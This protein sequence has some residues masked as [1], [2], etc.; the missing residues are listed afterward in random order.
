MKEIRT[1]GPITFA[2][3]MELSLYCPGLGY[4]VRN[5]PKIGWEGDYYTSP[6]LDSAF[7]QMIARQLV[8]MAAFVEG[9]FQVVEFGP[10]KGTMAAQ[11][12]QTLEKEAPQVLERLSYLLVEKSPYH[13]ELQQKAL[14]RH[15]KCTGWLAD[16]SQLAEFQGVILSNEFV[17]ALPVHRVTKRDGELREIM[18]G[19][20]EHGLYET[21]CPI[22]N[23][24]I[25]DYLELAQIN[26]NEGQTAEVNLA[27]LNWFKEVTAKL[28]RGYIITVDYGYE[29]HELDAPHRFDG[30][31]LSY[32]RHRVVADPYLVPGEQDI[33]AHVNFT[34]LRRQ[35]ELLGLTTPRLTSQMKFLVSQGILEEIPGWDEP[36]RETRLKAIKRLV[37]PE[38]LGETFKVLIQGKGV[39][40]SSLKVFNLW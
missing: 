14:S 23:Q 32:R 34:A 21:L 31:V 1:G 26:L 9:P 19:A 7:G 17:D 39:E 2:R 36:Q 25:L 29:S 4:Y 30:T 35:G 38:G 18:V 15:Q 5:M 22:T 20:N 37:M 6:D 28:S 13:R 40:V 3:F 8:E 11:I 16:H 27:A 10:G 12:L 24:E 33:T